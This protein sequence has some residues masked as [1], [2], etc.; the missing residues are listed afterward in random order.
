MSS[1]EKYAGSPD[2]VKTSGAYFQN[3]ESRQGFQ[4]DGCAIICK[5]QNDNNMQKAFLTRT[6]TIMEDFTNFDILSQTGNT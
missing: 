2:F 3:C 1:T 4:L 6:L 5:S